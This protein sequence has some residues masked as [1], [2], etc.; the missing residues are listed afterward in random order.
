MDPTL[1]LPLP[2]PPQPPTQPPASPPADM[3]PTLN[4]WLPAMDL[5]LSSSLPSPPPSTEPPALPPTQDSFNEYELTKL[6]SVVA[7]S[8]EAY[9]ILME[10][11]KELSKK[12]YDTL[13]RSSA[14]SLGDSTAVP[15]KLQGRKKDAKGKEDVESSGRLKSG[16][17]VN[18]GKRKRKYHSCNKVARHDSRNY[19]LNLK[20]RHN[21]QTSEVLDNDEDEQ[22]E[23][24][25]DIEISEDE[26]P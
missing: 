22:Q 3:D 21:S 4:Q 7:P 12:V 23:L 25:K 6:A 24:S 13:K 14:T 16:V 20:K 11:A 8:K 5:T 1:P 19:P 17:E 15:N 26:E 9:I 2:P 10:G 18:L